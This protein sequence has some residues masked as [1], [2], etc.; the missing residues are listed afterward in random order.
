MGGGNLA[1]LN[2]ES[3]S[4]TPRSTKDRRTIEI[5]VKSLGERRRGVSQETNL[6]SSAI[7]IRKE[8]PYLRQFAERDPTAQPRP[9]F[10][11]ELATTFAPSVS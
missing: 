3:I 9:S 1:V 7:G 11:V 8:G 10:Y 4:L 2:L 6:S 5:K